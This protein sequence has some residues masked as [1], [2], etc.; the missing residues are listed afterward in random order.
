MPPAWRGTWRTGAGERRR[1]LVCE[2]HRDAVDLADIELL[3][4]A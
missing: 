3:G 4:C 1:I 2:D